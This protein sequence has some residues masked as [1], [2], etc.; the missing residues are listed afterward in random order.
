MNLATERFECIRTAVPGPRSRALLA[1]IA[2]FEAQGVTFVSQTYPVVWASAHGSLVTDVDDNRYLDLT[3]AFGVANIGHTNERVSAAGR[4]A[5]AT[6]HS[7]H[8]RRA[9][10]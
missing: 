4:R 8:G 5:V 1:T 9:S 10:Q 7:R 3:A 2:E 6:P